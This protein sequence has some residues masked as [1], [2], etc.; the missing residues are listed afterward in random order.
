LFQ[1]IQK[2]IFDGF[3]KSYLEMLLSL[4]GPYIL[5]QHGDRPSTIW[6]ATHG[7]PGSPL[8]FVIASQHGV[9]IVGKDN[10]PNYR[11]R[12]DSQE[13]LAV[14]CLSHHPTVILAGTRRG[15]IHLI[16]VRLE[17]TKLRSRLGAIKHPGSICNI[18]QIDDDLIVVAGLNS[19]LCNYDLR[20]CKRQDRPKLWADS[21]AWSEPGISMPPNIKDIYVTTP[22]LTYP[23]HSNDAHLDLGFDI[24]AE[25]GIV[26][27]VQDDE[28][29]TVKVFSLKSGEVVQ[30][31]D[32]TE[33]GSSIDTASAKAVKFV[34]DRKD[35]G[36][37]SLWVAK[38]TK[39]VSYAW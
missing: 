25:A 8:G 34:K 23:D 3:A 5:A 31:L 1:C 2:S 26:A 11:Q 28:K 32:A 12:I 18:K 17:D 35:G 37:K 9:L 13:V 16:D 14:E 21:A 19:T 22:I 15:L 36:M 20:Y 38:G 6:G 39:M 24:D 7:A 4:T 10:T 29:Y 27:A 30:T 33:V